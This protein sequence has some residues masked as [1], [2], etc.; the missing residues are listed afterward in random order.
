MSTLWIGPAK[1]LDNI[2]LPMIGH[3]IGV[4]EDEIHV[5]LDVESRGSGFDAQGRPTML[6]E[7][8]VF[9][10]LLSGSEREAAVWQDLAYKNWG[11]KPY[12]RDSYPRLIAAM[13][14]NPMAALKS[15][16]W[17]I[18]QVMGFN[19][20]AAGYQTVQDMVAA[21]AM[22]EE[23]QLNAAVTF[24]INS[25]LDDELRRHDW[26]GFAR[27][28]NGPGYAK[29]RYAIKMKDSFAKWQRIKDTPWRPGAQASIPAPTPVAPK[30]EPVVVV[31]T[32][33]V[34]AKP[35]AAEVKPASGWTVIFAV[36]KAF[37]AMRKGK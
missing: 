23:F 20:K 1:R 6:F 26:D 28:Y 31:P 14:I 22:D 16:S 2:D 18:M 29:N 5:V 33:V 3:R 27:G 11:S 17:G 32:P 36:F 24:I 37:F 9:Y 10:R 19:H 4:G 7:P 15:C 35:I 34:P 25:K 21:F 12:P 8:H 13:K 30:P